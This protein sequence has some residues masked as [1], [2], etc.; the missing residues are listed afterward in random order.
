MDAEGQRILGIVRRNARKMGCLID[1]LLSLSRVGRK[2]LTPAALDM[3]GLVE[4][5]LEDLVPAASRQDLEVTVSDLP[6]AFGD[7]GLVRIVLQSI[8]SNALKFSAS[9]EPR[10]IEVGSVAGLVGTAYFVKDNGVGFD[11]RFSSKVFRAFERLHGPKEFEGTGIG[12]ALV[13]RVVDRHGGLVWAE[14]AVNEGAT[15]WFSLGPWEPA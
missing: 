14:G 3:K 5:V 2:E 7:A 4:S 15:F 10:V 8:L 1:D 6:A 12:L 9:R 11:P 13:R